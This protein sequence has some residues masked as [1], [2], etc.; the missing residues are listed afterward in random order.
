[1]PKVLPEYKDVIKSRIIGAA[2]IVFSKKGY[3]DSKIDEIAKE[4]GLSKPT[5]YK[6]IKSKED[7]LLAISESSIQQTEKSLSS[8]DQDTKTLLYNDYKLMVGS[9]EILHLGF[10]ITSL[11]T[12]D[13]NIQKIVRRKSTK[14][15]Q[16][17]YIF[18]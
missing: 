10:E 2:L 6:Y 9:K 7:I 8:Q 11:S 14:Q 3:H 5:L 1:M 4:A 17:P 18:Y 15:K 12:H 13:E 16:K